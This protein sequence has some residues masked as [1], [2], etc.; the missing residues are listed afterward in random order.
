MVDA[1]CDLMLRLDRLVGLESM[2]ST[3]TDVELLKR[4]AILTRLIAV[5]AESIAS[6]VFLRSHVSR[7]TRDTGELR[8]MSALPTIS[9]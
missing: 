3:Y 1:E 6:S 2:F 8:A 7:T 4:L 5:K 9:R